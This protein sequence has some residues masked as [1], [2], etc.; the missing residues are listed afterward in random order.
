MSHQMRYSRLAK[1]T[2]SLNSKLELRAVLEHVVSAISEEIVQ[3]E[4]VGIYLPQ[5]DGTY[6]GFVGKPQT[7]GGRTLDQMVADPATDLLV[8]ELVEKRQSIYIPDTSV[9]SRP[10]PR[11]VEWFQIQS[12]L[13]VPIVFEDDV[14]GL[15]FLFNYGR[16]LILSPEEIES[17]E[18][19]V[20]MAAVA[21]HNANLLQRTRTLLSEKQMLLEAVAALSRCSSTEQVLDTCFR[22]LRQAL[23]NPNIG[24]HLSRTISDPLRP[25]KLSRESEWT[26]RDWKDMHRRYEFD[27]DEDLL[28]QEVLRTKRPVM[29]PDVEEDPRPDRRLCAAFGIRG[30]FL[31]PLV[32]TDQVLGVVAIVSLGE[33]RAYT[34]EEM[35]LAQF[36]VDATATA[37]ANVIRMEKLEQIVK[38]RTAELEEKN[39]MLQDVIQEITRLSRQNELILQSAGD[40]IY[41]MD[42]QGRIT[43]CNLAA[44]RMIGVQADQ[45]VG[46]PHADVFR[47]SHD[48]RTVCSG[49]ECGLTVPLRQGITSEGRDELFWRTDGHAF[50]VEYVSTPIREGG[51]IVGAVVTF[52]DIGARKEME[53]QI[54]YH[55]YHDILTGLPNRLMFRQR[56]DA[57]IR[58]AEDRG[59]RLAVMFLDLDRFKYF[60]DTFGH[61]MGDL[62]LREVAQRLK[63]HVGA[64]YTVARLGG[65]EFTLVVPGLQ[66]PND[67]ARVAQS[68][69]RAF[70]APFQLGSY[71]FYITP[72]IGIS[73]YPE[74][75]RDFETLVKHADMAMYRCKD[76][77]GT[78]FQFYT[79]S[80]N[81]SV[82]ESIA[83]QNSLYRALERGEFQLFYQPFVD[84]VSG[85][86]TGMEALIR[87]RHP[88]LGLLSPDKFIPLAEETGFIVPIGEWVLRTACTQS[89]MWREMGLE[90]LRIS[91][92][93]SAQQ[94]RR[95]DLA[96]LVERVMRETGAVPEDLELE[97]TEH[98]LL[99]NSEAIRAAICRLKS[100]GIRISV[101]DFGTGYSSLEYLKQFPI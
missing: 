1:I 14:Y 23:R 92:N 32:A 62:L 54:E 93:L 61:S 67:A 8:R 37:L 19:Y 64:E 46:L 74:H 58:E 60:N 55:A 49:P 78:F 98:V 66:D 9:D 22:Y 4:A 89:R 53:A 5:P 39:E 26:E 35:Q 75:G 68:V 36:I 52:R 76:H 18:A 63:A 82:S 100:L 97:L 50:P 83:L 41:G 34:D 31:L 84:A 13:G 12:L 10:D 42:K 15:V 96:K 28:F 2:Q 6:R 59:D 94:F 45:I 86:I 95:D 17:I 33:P 11:P 24:V 70:E 48:G 7:I 91:V 87:W 80:M 40:G 101:D 47:H 44:A 27:Y 25:E 99:Q 85:R 90:P 29:I 30:L 43:F 56:L 3:C 38:Q 71:E 21:I 77:R 88:E 16:P 65:D 73:I 79:P 69:L 72:S 51:D 20:R 57:A 81:T